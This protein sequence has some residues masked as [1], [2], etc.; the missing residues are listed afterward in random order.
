CREA[1]TWQGLNHRFIL[2]LLGIDNQ[3]FPPTLCLVSPWMKRGTVLKYL[4]EHGRAEVNR[5]LLEIAHGLEYLHSMKI[6]HGDLHGTNILIS[7][8]C[9]AR[10]SDFGLSTVISEAESTLVRCSSSHAGSVRW[11]APE[12]LD[13]K[14]NGCERFVRTMATDV[15]AFGCVCLELHTG[16][17]PFSGLPDVS[18]AM[19]M[20]SGNRPKKPRRI[21]YRLWSLINAA[22]AQDRRSRPPI[23]EIVLGLPNCQ[24]KKDVLGEISSDNEEMGS[25]HTLMLEEN[26]RCPSSN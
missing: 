2:S 9:S 26:S 15:Y 8:D 19:Q 17:P 7:D 4:K 24:E 22:W 12:L 25:P 1:L 23:R 10:L 18:A 16:H 11:F 6:V 3:T 20:L 21:P 13:P 5:L 14:S